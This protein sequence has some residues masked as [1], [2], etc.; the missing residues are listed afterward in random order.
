VIVAVNMKTPVFF[1]ALSIG[2]A[3]AQKLSHQ[4]L[5]ADLFGDKMPFGIGRME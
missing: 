4:L 5:Y 2:F 3:M 1:G